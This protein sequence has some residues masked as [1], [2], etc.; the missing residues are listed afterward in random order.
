MTDS[1]AD[2]HPPY[3]HLEFG[4]EAPF[5]RVIEAERHF[6]RMIREV[7]GEVTGQP[8]GVQ[9]LV[10]G[11]LDAKALRLRLTPMP[12]NEEL[13]RKPNAM[14]HVVDAITDGVALLGRE[15]TRPDYFT[16]T[17]LTEA[18]EL[19]QMRDELGTLAIQNGKASATRIGSE[20]E[21]N[22]ATLVADVVT[23]Y[24]S[25]EG[26]VEGINLHGTTRYFRL[27]DPLTG[28]AVR[29]NFGRRIDLALIKEALGGRAAVYGKVTY[30]LHG[31]PERIEVEA[32]DPFPGNDDLPDVAALR[33]I[34]PTVT[35]SRRK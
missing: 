4:R 31:E 27:Y 20:F 3:L 34:L 14:S 32:I 15:A 6:D 25:V 23:E 2:T 28:R 7:S 29:C 10:V 12:M 19:A 26:A 5:G 22:V 17:A 8:D 1:M 33:G 11:L 35:V 21:A 30:G 13:E 9:W 18:L 24:G 16:S